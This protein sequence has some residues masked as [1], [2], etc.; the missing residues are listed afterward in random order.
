MPWK[1]E[2]LMLNLSFYYLLKHKAAME[3]LIKEREARLDFER[4]QTTLSED[5]GR[6]QREL[7][8]ANQKV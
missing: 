5:L 1:L 4:S 8:T 6:A 2:R 3:S 7:E